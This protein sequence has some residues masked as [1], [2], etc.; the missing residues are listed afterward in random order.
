MAMADFVIL[1]VSWSELTNVVGSALARE[2][3]S[4]SLTNPCPMTDTKVS[5][6]PDTKL[7]G[8]ALTTLGTGLGVCA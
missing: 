8:C 4:E 2:V 5:P 7:G 1:K 6:P 3:T